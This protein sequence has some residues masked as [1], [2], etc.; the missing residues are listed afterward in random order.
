MANASS[1]MQHATFL[2]NETR[3]IE[4]GGTKGGWNYTHKYNISRYTP[5]NVW[6]ENASKQVYV[7]MGIFIFH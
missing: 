5:L 7:G 2:H 1:N 6:S 4:G 3:G